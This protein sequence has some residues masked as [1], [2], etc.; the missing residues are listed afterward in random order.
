MAA[1]LA[2]YSPAGTVPAMGVGD[3]DT[4]VRRFCSFTIGTETKIVRYQ[5]YINS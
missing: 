3:D 1:Y 4:M 2:C 5:S